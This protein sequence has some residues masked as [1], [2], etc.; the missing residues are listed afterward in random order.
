MNKVKV[1]NYVRAVAVHAYQNDIYL[2]RVMLELPVLLA[3]LDAKRL[4]L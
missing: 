3:H 1:I 2:Q 4:K